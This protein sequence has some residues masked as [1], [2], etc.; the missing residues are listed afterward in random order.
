M[1]AYLK[2]LLLTFVAMLFIAI[3]HVTEAHAVENLNYTATMKVKNTLYANHPGTKKIMTVPKGAQV[4]FHY[5]QSN[6]WGY[7][8]YKGKKGTL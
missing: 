2:W 7:V 3:S 8:T 5:T 4:T 1:K 6:S